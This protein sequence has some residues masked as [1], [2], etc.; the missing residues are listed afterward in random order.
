VTNLPKEGAL[1]KIKMGFVEWFLFG[2][3]AVHIGL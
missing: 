3:Q 2:N 1:R